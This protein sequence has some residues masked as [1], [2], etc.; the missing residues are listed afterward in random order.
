[1]QMSHPSWS[2]RAAGMALATGLT[3]G[4]RDALRPDPD[5]PAVV[6]EVPGEPPPPGKVTLYFH[7]EVPEATLVLVRP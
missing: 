1:M 4:L 6:F 7:P 3:L 5:Q 2:R